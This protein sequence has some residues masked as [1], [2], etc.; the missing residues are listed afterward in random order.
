LRI[1]LGGIA[2]ESSTFSPLPSTL[3]DFRILRGEE[4]GARYPFLADWRFRGR[5]DVRW[6]P[7]LHAGAIPGGPVTADAYAALKGELLE[8]VRGQHQVDAGPGMAFLRTG[9]RL[10][11]TALGIRR[12]RPPR[13]RRP[14]R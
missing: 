5:D 11:A 2:I 4:L 12:A 8:R 13:W 10:L 9:H 1:G 14:G 7:V 6:V 3:G